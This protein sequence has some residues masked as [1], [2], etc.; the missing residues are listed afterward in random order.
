MLTASAL[1]S[2]G[3][4]LKRGVLFV[5]DPAARIATI[6]AAGVAEIPFTT[7]ILIG[8][9]ETREERL[10]ALFVI[11]DLHRRY[12]HI[13][14]SEWPSHAAWPACP[15][16]SA[17]AG[18]N[19]VPAMC[20]AL[21]GLFIPRRCP[22]MPSQEIIIQNFRAK[23]GTA[24]AAAPEPP[25][26]ELLWTTAMARIILGPTA[27]IQ[28]RT[29][30]A[31]PASSDWPPTA[32]HS[33][34]AR[35]MKQALPATSSA[36]C[37]PHCCTSQAGRMSM[38]AGVYLRSRQSGR[39]WWCGAGAPEPDS[40]GAG[41]CGGGWQH[42]GGVGGPAGRWPQRLGRPVA[43]H[44]GLRQPGEAVAPHQRPGC[45]DSA[46]GLPAAAQVP[47]AYPPSGPHG[48]YVSL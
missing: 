45:R 38:P 20:A 9:G 3:G 23:K 15:P 22:M 12:G 35:Q 30:P 31:H 4:I 24:M 48:P 7:G 41:G 2:L 21:C 29:P 33:A 47:L 34:H 46:W 44:P 1:S 6:A 43:H 32:K 10:D 16:A 11:R 25:L 13:Q 37:S 5:Q 26:E 40:S 36:D 18:P 19:A 27:N 8:I 28:V 17:P 39:A 42:G 14:A